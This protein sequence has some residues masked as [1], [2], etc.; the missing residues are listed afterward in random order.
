MFCKKLQGGVDVFYLKI[1]Q[2]VE[3]ALIIN[4][5]YVFPEQEIITFDYLENLTTT[6]AFENG[7]Y[8]QTVSFKIPDLDNDFYID[9]QNN[10]YRAFVKDEND[11]WMVFGVQNGMEASINNEIGTNKSD[12]NGHNIALTGREQRAFFKTVEEQLGSLFLASSSIVSSTS[13]LISESTI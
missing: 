1:F 3:R 4:D 12:F 7:Y 11:K 10:E 5:G 9:L 6:S 8:N 13:K 2:E